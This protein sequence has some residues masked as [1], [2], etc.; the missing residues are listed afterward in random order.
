[1]FPGLGSQAQLARGLGLKVTKYKLSEIADNI[2]EI[3]TILV[4]FVEGKN[5]QAINDLIPGKSDEYLTKARH[6]ILRLVPQISFAMGSVSL[7]LKEQLLSL[8]YEPEAIPFVVRNLATM[9]RE[10]L[11][12][13]EKLQYKMDR[14]AYLR[15]QIHDALDI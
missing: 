9:V 15:V 4:A 3:H 10:G 13:Q 14:R 5:Y 6:F 2:T 1:M 7:T 12:T 11:D 8:N